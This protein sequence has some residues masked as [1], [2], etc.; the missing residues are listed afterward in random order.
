MT[1]FFQETDNAGANAIQACSANPPANS[2]ETNEMAVGG[3]VGTVELNCSLRGAGE[4]SSLW[5]TS[6]TNSPNLTQWEAG[7]AVV[8]YNVTTA[9]GA[10]GTFED[11]NL[12]QVDSTGATKASYG[13]A[14]NQAIDLT[15]TGVKTTNV[16]V[17]QLTTLATDRLMVIASGSHPG[18][19]SQTA[20]VTPDQIIDMPSLVA[21]GAEVLRRR[22]EGHA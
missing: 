17:G 19:G 22:I 5:F 15:T 4:D 6:P 7:T 2:P 13:S 14:L 21:A 10:S 16:T 12:C 8:R 1:I 3:T 9:N 11:I 20:G 18:M